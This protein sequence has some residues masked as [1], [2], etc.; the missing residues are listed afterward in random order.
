MLTKLL[1]LYEKTLIHETLIHE[2]N[3]LINIGM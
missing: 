3:D 1:E 2:I